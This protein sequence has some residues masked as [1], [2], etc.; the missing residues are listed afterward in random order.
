MYYE[1]TKINIK[2]KQNKTFITAI[3]PFNRK[4]Y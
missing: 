3:D 1:E 2:Y 4:I